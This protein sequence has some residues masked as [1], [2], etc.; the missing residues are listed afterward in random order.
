DYIDGD[1]TIFEQEPLIN[2]AL[3]GKLQ[4]FKHDGF[5][6][7]MDTMRD[8]FELNEMWDNGKAPWKIW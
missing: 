6:Q 3:E 8:N 5:W 1:E 7:P 4:A 2:L